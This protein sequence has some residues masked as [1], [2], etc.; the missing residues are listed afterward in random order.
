MTLTTATTTALASARNKFPLPKGSA[1]AEPFSLNITQGIPMTPQERSLIEAALPAKR[2]NH[3]EDE[4]PHLF[5]ALRTHVY[6]ALYLRRTQLAAQNPVP[7]AECDDSAPYA[8]G[9][10]VMETLARAL[11]VQIA[12]LNA[13]T[14]AL[15]NRWGIEGIPNDQ[16]LNTQCF[17]L[18]LVIEQL[19]HEIGDCEPDLRKRETDAFVDYCT[20]VHDAW[21]SSVPHVLHLLNYDLLQS[22][23]NAEVDPASAGVVAALKRHVER[24]A[25]HRALQSTSPRGPADERIVCMGFSLHNA[26]FGT[27]FFYTDKTGNRRVHK[28]GGGGWLRD[29][30]GF[31]AGGQEAYF[32]NSMCTLVNDMLAEIRQHTSGKLTR[33]SRKKGKV[34]YQTVCLRLDQD[35]AMKVVFVPENFFEH[36]VQGILAQHDAYERIGHLED[37]TG[38]TPLALTAMHSGPSLQELYTVHANLRSG[39][40]FPATDGGKRVADEED[41]TSAAACAC[42]AG[43]HPVAAG[44]PAAQ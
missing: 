7:Q 21:D 42:E 10:V 40:A 18:M 12:A 19:L 8:Q 37:D 34:K 15:F 14:A 29:A 31:F 11:A 20:R 27:L 38:L 3:A 6:Q 26:N 5:T 24:L 30:L 1:K 23:F 2:T 28:C 36:T 33:I 9:Q 43:A 35:T 39:I 44:E 17:Q 32:P 4:L 13:G 25:C 16:P 41:D 22:A